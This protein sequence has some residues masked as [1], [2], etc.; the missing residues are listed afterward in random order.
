[1]H[2]GRSVVSE[3]AGVAADKRVVRHRGLVASVAVAAVLAAYGALDALDV[4]PGVLTVSDPAASA[5]P[6]AP[7]AAPATGRWAA[8]D[9]ASLPLA[10]PRGEGSAP[11]ADALAAALAPLLAARALGRSVGADVRDA[12]TGERLFGQ[13]PAAARTPASTAKILTAAAIAA[14]G[15]LGRTLDTRAVR[16]AD[17]SVVLVAGGDTLLAPGAGDPLSVPGRAGLGD[18]AEQVAESLAGSAGAAGSGP[19]RVL[20]DDRALSGPALAPTWESADVAAGYVGTVAPLGL[21]TRRP[22]PGAPVTGDTALVAAEAF[23]TQLAARGVSVARSVVRGEAPAGGDVLGVVR[24]APLGDQL[25]LAL[26]ESDNTLTEALAR[27]AAARHGRPTTFEAAAAWVSEQ[28]RTQTAP[29]GTAIRLVDTS[30]LSAGSSVPPEVL[31]DLVVG[32][33]NGSMPDL[34]RVLAQLPV[35][36][37]TGTLA[38]RYRVPATRPGAGLVRAKTGTLSEV[39]SL[40][41]TVVD[42]DGRLLAFAIL[43]DKVPPGGT[44][45][46]RAA[47][48]TVTATLAQCGCRG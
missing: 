26:D 45:A 4:A 23:R 19:L 5:P 11:T 8:G 17:G 30:G 34:A 47:L 24:S 20:L 1:M 38:E 22:L 40:A 32:A 44:E 29:A 31:T 36:G 14:D 41:G 16:G 25:A 7:A 33:A 37:L 42:A 21:A 18:L 46:S 48:D 15:D 13:E 39:S 2:E 6:G 27:L 10:P 3:G 35:A 43:A 9:P 28:L 12:L